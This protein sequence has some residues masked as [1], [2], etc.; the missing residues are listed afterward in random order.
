[1]REACFSN[2]QI[3][4][5]SIEKRFRFDF[6]VDLYEFVRG[7]DDLD[8]EYFMSHCDLKIIEVR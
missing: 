2:G 7:N 5:L 1:M 4:S 6:L 3:F 8:Y